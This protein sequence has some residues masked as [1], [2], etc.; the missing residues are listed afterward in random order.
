MQMIL[1]Q[2]RTLPLS[3]A[4]LSLSFA[5]AVVQGC[6]PLSLS[7]LLACSSLS[8]LSVCLCPKPKQESLATET[9]ACATYVGIRAL[10]FNGS[11]RGGNSHQL[12]SGFL[13][14]ETRL[15]IQGT[16]FQEDLVVLVLYY[17]IQHSYKDKKV[18]TLLVTPTS[19]EELAG[20]QSEL[21]SCWDFWA[22][23]VAI[24][25]SASA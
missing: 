8:P 10:A 7:L 19:I 11:T 4:T 24:R 13:P 9:R 1:Q 12:L 20:L 16:I 22:G 23:T 3:F 17:V 18:R 5:R 21:L 6:Y 14:V 15:K 2:A 25:A